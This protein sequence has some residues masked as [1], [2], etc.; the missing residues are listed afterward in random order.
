MHSA[1]RLEVLRT[2]IRSD[3]ETLPDKPVE[4]GPEETVSDA[5]DG[6][7]SLYPPIDPPH[8]SSESKQVESNPVPS[9]P[10][11]TATQANTDRQ[12]VWAQG[13]QSSYNLGLTPKLS[14]LPSVKLPPS[15]LSRGDL[16]SISEQFT[17][18]GALAKYPY[19]FVNRNLMQDIASVFFAQSMS[20]VNS[21]SSVSGS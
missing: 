3:I 5:E 7:V 10:L 19:N 15:A 11:P 18:I 13:Q 9:Q 8:V 6:G 17:P 12:F 2:L 16:V 20:S 14:S 1:A 4:T 21:S